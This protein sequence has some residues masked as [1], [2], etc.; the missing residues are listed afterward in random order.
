MDFIYTLHEKA[1]LGREFLTWLWFASSQGQPIE[2]QGGKRIEVAFLDRL[3]FS[4]DSESP[5]TVLLRG[6]ESEF[7]E[8]FAALREGKRIE[9]ARIWLRS[10]DYDFIVSL[11]AVWFTFKSL[12]TPPVTLSRDAAPDEE[13]EGFLLEKLSLLEE[14]LSLID[15]LFE[16]FVRLRISDQ[17]NTSMRHALRRW[18]EV[19]AAE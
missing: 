13:F 14:A 2:I 15:A 3:R 18:V 11:G 6:D 19:G 16:H 17:W 1:F 12:T 9:E 10:G 8:G 4:K 5:Q 7:R